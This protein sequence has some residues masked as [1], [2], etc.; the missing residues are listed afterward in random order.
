MNANEEKQAVSP[1]EIAKLKAIREAT[2]EVLAQHR[3]EILK[4]AIAKLQTQ[5]IQITQQDLDDAGIK[6]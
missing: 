4:L 2:F 1:R 5:G 6:V 3:L